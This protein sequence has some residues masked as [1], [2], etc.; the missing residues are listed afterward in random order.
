MKPK[1]ST[2][3]QQLH[4]MADAIAECD[5]HHSDAEQREAA[6]ALGIEDRLPEPQEPLPVARAA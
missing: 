6:R 1:P 3:A 5:R 4:H 2:V